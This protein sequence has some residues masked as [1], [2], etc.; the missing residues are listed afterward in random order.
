MSEQEALSEALGEQ[1]VDVLDTAEAGRRVMVGG[2]VRVT[3]FVVGVGASVVAAAFVTRHLGT[4]DYGRYQ[5]VVALVTIVQFL[6]DLGMETLGLREYSQRDGAAR[7]R[8]MRVLLGLRLFL[9]TLGV[10]VMA[11]VAYA[12]GYDSQMILGAAVMGVGILV[13]VMAGTVAIPLAAGLRLKWVTALDLTRQIVTA[14]LSIAL[15]AAGAGIVG[16]L[17][18]PIPAYLVVLAGALMLVHGT[19]RL[20]PVVDRRAWLAL[21]RPAITFAL[22]TATGAVYVYAAQV[23]TELVAS[24]HEAGLFGASF[25][26]YII[27][28]SVPGILVTSAFPLLSRAAR[29]DHARLAY[30]TQRLFEGTAVLG[31]AALVGCVLGAAPVIAV[32]AGPQFDGAADVLRIQ[33]VALAL[34]FVIATWGFTLLAMHRHRQMIAANL[35]AL[36]VSATTVLILARSHGAQGAAFGTLLGELTLSTGYVIGLSRADPRMRPGLR[37]AWRMLP[38]LAL[39]LACGLLPVPDAVATVLGLAVY[40]AGVL[41]LGALPDEVRERLPAPLDR[42]GLVVRDAR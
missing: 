15:V 20:S 18:V 12:I 26:V 40:G 9:T 34:T 31:G 42:V 2:A 6:T 17:A 28:A 24:H 39:A 36:A 16:F 25:R 23:L 1:A 13:A 4:A 32:V 21:V 33:G 37:R 38:A 41:L 5:S 7:E 8:F 35:V 11:L 3:G 19:V 10:G 29:D 14:V 27:L 22:A 30:A